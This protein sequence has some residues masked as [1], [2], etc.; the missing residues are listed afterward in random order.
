MEICCKIYTTKSIKPEQMQ[1]LYLCLKINKENVQQFVIQRTK[2]SKF[3][4]STWCK[5]KY[6]YSRY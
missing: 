5:N 4:T 2:Y 3:S 6:D 1:N